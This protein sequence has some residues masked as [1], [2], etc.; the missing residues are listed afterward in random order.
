MMS[1]DQI[2]TL[3]QSGK[4]FIYHLR[5]T[6]S[7]REFENFQD[8]LHHCTDWPINGG[9]GFKNNFELRIDKDIYIPVR[10]IPA[11]WSTIKSEDEK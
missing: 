11:A 4:P 5:A 9:L 3:V 6:T 2:R 10:I 7:H 1:N 8:L